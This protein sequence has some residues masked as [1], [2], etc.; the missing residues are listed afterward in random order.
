MGI[1][2]RIGQG[3]GRVKNVGGRVKENIAGRIKSSDEEKSVEERL[4]EQELLKLERENIAAAKGFKGKKEARGSGGTSDNGTIF[5]ISALVIYLLDLWG[6]FGG[7]YTGFQW[8][9]GLENVDILF[10]IVTSSIF[11]LFMLVY[12]INRVIRREWNLMDFGTISFILFALVMTFFIMNNQ[13]FASPKAIIHFIFILIFGFT[14]I[15]GREDSSTAYIYIVILLLLD[16]FGYSL[17]ENIFI[18][19]Y[20]PLLFFFTVLYVYQQTQSR[21]SIFFFVA[22]LIVLFIFAYKDLQAQGGGF[23]FIADDKGITAGDL[24]NDA[25]SG[26]VG[27]FTSAKSSFQQQ[28]QYAITGKVEENQ[29]EPL[30][31]YLEDVQPAE[32]SFYEDE[33]VIVW[34]SVKARTLD[35]PINIEVGCFVKNRRNIHDKVDPAKKFSVFAFEEQDFACTFNGCDLEEDYECEDAKVKRGSNIVTTFA[36]FNFETLANLKVYFINRERQ[37]AMIREGLDILEEF[38]IKDTNPIAIYTNGPAAIEMGTTTPLVGVSEDYSRPPTLSVVLKNR[39]GWQGGLKELKELVIFLPHGVKLEIPDE[40]EEDPVQPCIKKFIPYDESACK[41]ESCRDFVY[42]ECAEVCGDSSFVQLKYNGK[43]STTSGNR[44]LEECVENTN[45]CV[46][47]CTSLFSEGD[48]KYNAYA[49]DTKVIE[50]F[51][52]KDFERGKSFRCVINASPEVLENTPVTTKFFRVKA[53]YNYVVEETVN[54]RIDKLPDEV[55]EKFKPKETE[56]PIDEEGTI[57]TLYSLTGHKGKRLPIS[58]DISDLRTKDFNDEALSLKLDPG[59]V[60]TLYEHDKFGGYVDG[61][62]DN[63]PGGWCHTYKDSTSILGS[64]ALGTGGE[65]TSLRIYKEFE[66][67]IVYN[68][69]NFD[70]SGKKRSEYFSGRSSNFDDRCTNNNQISSIEV[71]PGYNVILYRNE[72]SNGRDDVDCDFEN[73]DDIICIKGDQIYAPGHNP[74]QVPSLGNFIDGIDFDN[75]A[76]SLRIIKAG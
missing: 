50:S 11:G 17:L 75:A 55:R 48:Q 63:N 2:D 8:I 10:N 65:V 6:G 69:D 23:N 18:F 38:G 45:K 58:K 4:R 40:N 33:K 66:G 62:K 60:V 76:S 1:R 37:R 67:A 5:L 3:F 15:K 51:R 28:I 43:Y 9:W 49:L 68:S 56:E 61:Q 59:Y 46:D 34:G 54:V 29:F 32:P 24:W 22:V 39:E 12:V 14:F 71:A 31:V 44:C 47:V 30:G 64:I 53:R 25:K 52:N 26:F 35:D 42:K 57:G 73:T 41:A 70:N 27:I 7:R 19:R 74:G 20:V 16:F 21:A 72:D 36:N 13:W